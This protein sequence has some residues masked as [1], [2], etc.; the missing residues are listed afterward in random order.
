[1]N[2]RCYIVKNSITELVEFDKYDIDTNGVV[3]NKTTGG[4]LR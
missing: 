3:T 1:M 4:K 2:L